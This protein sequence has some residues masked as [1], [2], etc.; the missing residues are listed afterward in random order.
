M[1]VTNKSNPTVISRTPYNGATYTHQGW[2]ADDVE[3]THLLLDDELDEQEGNGPASNKRT[4]TYL[5]DIS[6]LKEPINTGVYQSSALAIDHNLYVKDG[7]AYQSN[8]SSGLRIVDVSSLKEDSTGESMTE[9]GFFDCHP[10]DDNEN[11][12]DFFGSWSSYP[13]F[14][15]GYILLNSI[16]RGVY[17]VKYTGN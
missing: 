2:L 8:Y 7:K 9:V 13:Y 10:E 14:P 1:D 15:S 3:M 12:V 17:S 16:E 6:N 11:V 4:T 5:F